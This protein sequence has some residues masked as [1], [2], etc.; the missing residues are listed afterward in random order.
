MQTLAAWDAIT[1]QDEANDLLALMGLKPT[2]FSEQE[3]RT[4]PLNRLD[5]SSRLASLPAHRSAPPSAPRSSFSLPAPMTSLIGR[6]PLVELICERLR[7]PGVRLLTLLDPGGIGKTRVGLEVARQM[8]TEFA[9]GVFFVSLAATHDPTW[10]PSTIAQVIGGGV[11]SP[12]RI[13]SSRRPSCSFNVSAI[14]GERQ[15]AGP[16]RTGRPRS[17]SLERG[18]HVV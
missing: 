8:R 5:P 9:D 12:R 13:R 17:R 14:A 18:S 15:H 7:E 16:L 10:V 11:T 6:Q 2:S 1:T 4:A 3:W